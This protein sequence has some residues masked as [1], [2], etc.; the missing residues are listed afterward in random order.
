[1]L[2]AERGELR[3]TPR[4][5]R[6]MQRQIR[7]ICRWSCARR[8]ESFV[9]RGASGFSLAKWGSRFWSRAIVAECS[10]NVCVKLASKPRESRKR[11]KRAV[12]GRRYGQGEN[13]AGRRVRTG[14]GGVAGL[15]LCATW[16]ETQR[17]FERKVGR[18]P[19]L[20][21]HAGRF[22]GGFAGLL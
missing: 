19:G 3:E 7:Q 9:R 11:K 10:A 18:A 15:S 21:C 20:C 2:A 4:A 12:M 1:M 6:G 5:L 14:R 13:P 8:C 16:Q 17:Q 22:L